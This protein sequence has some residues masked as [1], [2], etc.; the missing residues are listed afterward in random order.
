MN[1]EVTGRIPVTVIKTAM[2]SPVLPYY[3]IRVIKI[4]RFWETAHLPLPHSR[5]MLA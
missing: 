1:T 5:Q 2:F 3:A 4:I